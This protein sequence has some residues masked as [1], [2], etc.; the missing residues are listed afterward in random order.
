MDK[1]IS[2]FLDSIHIDYAE[3]VSLAKKTWIH[4]GPIVPYYIQPS[5]VDELRL[6]VEFLCNNKKDFKVI[7]HTSNLYFKDTF[8]TDAIITTR[9][10]TVFSEKEGKLICDA[11][12]N[13]SQLSKYCVERGIMGF[14]GLVGLPGTVAAAVVNNSSCFKCSI[15][16]L[17][18]DV[19]VILY[20]S[21]GTC[22]FRTLTREE[23]GFSH[24]SSAIKRNEMNAIV[25]SVRLKM[26]TTTDIEELKRKAQHNIDLRTK[27]QEGKAQNL[28]SVYASR[29]SKPL[30]IFDLGILKFPLMLGLRVT[31]H[32]FRH[33]EWYKLN[34][35]SYLLILFG[36]KDVIPYVSPK[37]INCFIW[38]DSGADSAF[39]RYDAF[40]H[41]CFECGEMEIEICK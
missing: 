23:L 9:K 30:G 3:N 41:E 1:I 22:S 37:N 31:D 34:R 28:G 6:V 13:V 25:L 29:K 10:M 27:T 19:D 39:G 2:Q 24:R 14:E 4:R 26:N 11:G 8:H 38:K 16:E 5:N 36:Y 33:K 18:T 20:E 40:M 21:N 32:F 17:L 35:N 12:V 15:Y 7:G